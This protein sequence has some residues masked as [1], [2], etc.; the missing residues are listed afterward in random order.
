MK[1]M[2]NTSIKLAS[3][4]LTTCLCTSVIAGATYALLTDDAKV[5]IAVTSGKVAVSATVDETSLKCYSVEKDDTGSITVE[6][7]DGAYSWVQQTGLTFYCGGSVSW[8]SSTSKLTV[9]DMAAGDKVTFNINVTNTSTIDVAYKVEQTISGELASDLTVTALYNNENLADTY[10]VWK[11]PDDSDAGETRAVAVT[12]ELPVTYANSESKS[13]VINFSVYAVQSNGIG[14][15]AEDNVGGEVT[16]PDTG[17]ETGDNTGDETGDNSGD[18]ENTGDTTKSVANF[19]DDFTADTQ[20]GSWKYGY[21]DYVFGES[22]SFT[23]TQADTYSNET[24]TVSGVE[25][26]EIKKGWINAGNMTTV[27]YTVTE[28]IT[29]TITF[30]FTGS[31]DDTRLA[32]RVGVKDSSDA[33]Y[34]KPTYKNNSDSNVLEYT[35]TTTLNAGDT[36]YFIF[37]NENSDNA[38][39]YPNGNLSIIITEQ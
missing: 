8:D 27:A 36:I 19:A 25:G 14:V 2:T 17:D 22:E 13:A 18:G 16:T 29:V 5:D 4:A 39:A 30:T 6:G 26:V 15:S 20:N 1:M 32:L 12:I 35:S 9:T 21:V 37:S 7:Y 33:L 10:S 3:L 24:W 38:S 34:S 31:T 11:A 28:D 23:F